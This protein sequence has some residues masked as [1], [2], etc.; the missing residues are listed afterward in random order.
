MATAESRVNIM[1]PSSGF[2]QLECKQFRESLH[3]ATKNLHQMLYL[4][5]PIQYVLL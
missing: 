4:V 1:C 2:M 5:S 3:W